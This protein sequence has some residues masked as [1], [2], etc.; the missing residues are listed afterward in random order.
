METK[1]CS[2]ATISASSFHYSKPCMICGESVK[3]TDWEEEA[4]KFGNSV[5]SKICDKCKQAVLF[6]RNKINDTT[7]TTNIHCDGLN[8]TDTNGQYSNI[9]YC[10]GSNCDKR[11]E[12]DYHIHSK[13]TNSISQYIDFSTQ[14]SGGSNQSDTYYCGNNG[15][16]A[17]F[18]HI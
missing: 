7:D 3:L 1:R 18:K 8:L 16:Y 2:V 12:C 11:D 6:I 15:N 13:N 9:P 4:L 5:E 14:G 17:K 10:E